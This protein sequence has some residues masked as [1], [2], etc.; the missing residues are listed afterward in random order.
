MDEG[1]NGADDTHHEA[2][3][4]VQTYR[5]RHI[6][7]ELLTEVTK[8]AALISRSCTNIHLRK[9]PHL[10][11]YHPY[12]RLLSI[13]GVRSPIHH[14]NRL[15]MAQ[16]QASKPPLHDPPATQKTTLLGPDS[17]RSRTRSQSYQYAT[18]SGVSMRRASVTA[19]GAGYGAITGRSA[20][21]T[22]G[23][24]MER[25][26]IKGKRGPR[27]ALGGIRWSSTASGTEKGRENSGRRGWGRKRISAVAGILLLGTGVLWTLTQ[28]S[29]GAN[30]QEFDSPPSSSD[31]IAS[32]TSTTPDKNG[33]IHLITLPFNLHT[34]PPPSSPPAPSKPKPSRRL[35]LVG[36]VH[37]ALDE[38]KALLEK[39]DFDPGNHADHLVLTGDMVS[40]GPKSR[41]VLDFLEKLTNDG[42][43]SCVRGNHDDRV[44]RAYKRL[45]KQQTEEE[46]EGVE[47]D[48]P[49]AEEEEGD[50][51]PDEDILDGNLIDDDD[52]VGVSK[53]KKN[54]RRRQRKRASDDAVAKTLSPNQARYLETCPLVL[55]V[56]GAGHDGGDLLVVHAGI[57]PGVPLLKQNPELL[58]NMRTILP[59][60]GAKGKGKGGKHNYGVGRGS[61]TT[62]GRHWAEVWNEWEEARVKGEQGGEENR[63]PEVLR[64]VNGPEHG[65]EEVGVLGDEERGLHAGENVREQVDEGSAKGV[66][67]VYGHYA[68]KGLDVRRW[69]KGLDSNCVRGGRL[70][71]LVVKREDGKGKEVGKGVDM[72]VVSVK[73]KKYAD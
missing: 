55:R 41:E 20:H 34:P 33:Y 45:H 65:D 24:N 47:G 38:L 36:D 35:I 71:A 11:P 52:D 66:T 69:T 63:G 14:I 2:I 64:G 15:I 50:V 22:E 21:G 26:E 23:N 61:S 17:G 9:T 19:P 28:Y 6:I 25:G 13:R 67:V 5:E 70:S 54:S 59:P 4:V 16:P 31:L 58:M 29:F 18:G 37:G 42:V 40:K 60:K 1:R 49:A 12:H 48:V 39:V 62:K 73:C 8:L 51:D 7:E 10:F 56:H 32:R 43:A 68:A 46:I 53:K 3:C 30:L 44:L 57:V 72:Q 27:P